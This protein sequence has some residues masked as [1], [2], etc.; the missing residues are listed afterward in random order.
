MDNEEISV[1][2]ASILAIGL[3]ILIITGGA[4]IRHAQERDCQGI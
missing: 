4:K 2:I 1:V 3:V